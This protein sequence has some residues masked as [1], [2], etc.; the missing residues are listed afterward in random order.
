MAGEKVGVWGWEDGMAS[1]GRSR[2]MASAQARLT[3]V[4]RGRRK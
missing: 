1:A 3:S 2:Y 4:K